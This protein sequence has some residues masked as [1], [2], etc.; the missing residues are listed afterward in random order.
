MLCQTQNSENLYQPFLFTKC[1][2]DDGATIS[3]KQMYGNKTF[4][5]YGTI[6][7]Q[8]LQMFK[9]HFNV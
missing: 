3:S 4:L 2:W 5:C 7:N 9:Y 1:M 6:H 8:E